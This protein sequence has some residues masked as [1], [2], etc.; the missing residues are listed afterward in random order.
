MVTRDPSRRTD[1]TVI[2]GGVLSMSN[3][4]LSIAPVSAVVGE[5]DGVSAA[6]TRTK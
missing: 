2:A 4:V 1:V 3:E 5:F 6:T